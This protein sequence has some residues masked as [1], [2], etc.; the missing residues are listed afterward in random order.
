M[1][2]AGDWQEH[3]FIWQLN[4]T[5]D[6]CWRNAACVHFIIIL[7]EKSVGFFFFPAE[8]GGRTWLDPVQRVHQWE[9]PRDGGGGGGGCLCNL[10]SADTDRHEELIGAESAFAP[11][12]GA[13]V[14]L[15]TSPLCWSVMTSHISKKKKEE[16]AI[17]WFAN[18][19]L[20]EPICVIECGELSSPSHC[21]RDA[22]VQM[23]SVVI[24]LQV[25]GGYLRKPNP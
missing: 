22:A 7:L 5:E 2:C 20:I 1:Q 15:G 4:G 18:A 13:D 9:S 11:H 10:R 12:G 25:Y 21:T 3:I 16:E 14:V 17:P 8:V 19:E 24:S 6:K 23:E